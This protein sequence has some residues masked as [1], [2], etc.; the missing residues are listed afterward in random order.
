[1]LL[2]V[3][4]SGANYKMAILDKDQLL[5]ITGSGK[6]SYD[7]NYIQYNET[8]SSCGTLFS[9]QNIKGYRVYY[10]GEDMLYLKV[11]EDS[12]VVP[13]SLYKEDSTFDS[14]IES[15]I[16]NGYTSACP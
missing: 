12:S 11:Y 10:V 4:N 5:Y 14:L 13:V 3:S 9:E 7:G 2:E 15:I 8:P 1:M 6:I 16:A